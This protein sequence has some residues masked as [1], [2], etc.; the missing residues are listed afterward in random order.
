[1]NHN[2]TVDLRGISSNLFKNQLCPSMRLFRLYVRWGVSEEC[3]KVSIVPDPHH[4]G[5][6]RK[7]LREAVISF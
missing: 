6:H 1:M 5:A 4:Y 7:C 3:D 2:V